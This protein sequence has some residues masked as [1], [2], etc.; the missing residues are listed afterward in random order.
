LI[1]KK[2]FNIN[3][4]LLFLLIAL[5]VTGCGYTTR[6]VLPGGADSIHVDNFKNKIDITEET[7][8]RRIYILYRPGIE[9]D[10]TREVI[11]RFILD[12]NMKIANEENAALVLVGDLVDFRKE[13]LRYDANDNPVEFRIK[14]TVNVKLEDT[15]TG[16]ILWREH[17][18]TGES[19]YTPGGEF[20]KSESAASL[21]A[22]QDLARRI[23]ERTVE[24]W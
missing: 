12:G 18:F 21:E 10:V 11:D 20:A 7:S 2:S 24:G 6:T 16:N 19:I 9:L 14:V 5:L 23:V 17:N 3:P 8:D 13:V 1:N 15:K 22:I 4:V